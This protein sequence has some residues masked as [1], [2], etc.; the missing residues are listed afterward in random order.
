MKKLSLAMGCPVIAKYWKYIPKNLYI[1][2]NGKTRGQ[3][4]LFHILYGNKQIALVGAEAAKS[5]SR[6]GRKLKTNKSATP[7]PARWEETQKS[8]FG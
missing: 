6:K 7:R 5:G 3:G 8:G 4:Y 2:N 1:C